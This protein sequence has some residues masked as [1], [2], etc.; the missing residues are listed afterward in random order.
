MYGGQWPGEG[1][2]LLPPGA[3]QRCTDQQK[4]QADLRV[5]FSFSA[6]DFL[7]WRTG[8]W[9]LRLERRVAE[10]LTLPVMIVVC[11][12]LLGNL[13]H[14]R[15]MIFINESDHF[16]LDEY[17]IVAMVGV[18]VDIRSLTLE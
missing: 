10:K 18:L 5:K 1:F 6:S 9:E 14:L 13:A 4:A 2:L 3:F 11:L 12:C 7:R 8:F 16:L 15:K 17:K